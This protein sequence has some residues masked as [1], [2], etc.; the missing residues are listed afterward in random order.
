MQLH[1]IARPGKFLQSLPDSRNPFDRTV[2]F[3]TYIYTYMCK[4]LVRNEMDFVQIIATGNYVFGQ[5]THG[6][7]QMIR[8]TDLKSVQ[9]NQKW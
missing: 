2:L 6:I 1:K 5:S 9:P 7:C 8:V 4:T 3:V